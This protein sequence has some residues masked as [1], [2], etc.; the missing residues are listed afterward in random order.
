MSEVKSQK[1][2][3]ATLLAAWRNKK[4]FTLDKAAQAIGCDRY[5]LNR[6]ENGIHTPQGKRAILIRDLCDVPVESWYL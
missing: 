6:Y 2:Q 1:N 3:G 5:M 4:G